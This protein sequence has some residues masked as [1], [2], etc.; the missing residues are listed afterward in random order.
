MKQNKKTLSV[1]P[2]L[3]DRGMKYKV[4]N[5]DDVVKTFATDKEFLKYAKAIYKENEDGQ[6]YPSEIYW[7]PENVQQAKEYI[8]EYCQNLTLEEF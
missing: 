3:D 2:P 5:I 1:S 6:P 8:H 7:M 4:T